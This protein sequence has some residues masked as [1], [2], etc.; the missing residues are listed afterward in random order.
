MA[1]SSS[2]LCILDGRNVASV[3]VHSSPLPLRYRVSYA[4]KV[5]VTF[6]HVFEQDDGS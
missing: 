6:T 2:I 4:A 5:V 1:I 3:F